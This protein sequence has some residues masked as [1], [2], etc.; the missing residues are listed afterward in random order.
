MLLSMFSNLNPIR[1]GLLK[2]WAIRACVL[3]IAAWIALIQQ[4]Y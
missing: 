1:S 4:V 3:R 2:W